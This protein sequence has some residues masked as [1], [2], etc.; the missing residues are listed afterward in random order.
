M[1]T[2]QM[3][4]I[5][6]FMVK[7]MAKRPCYQEE[8]SSSTAFLSGLG[9]TGKT[10]RTVLAGMRAIAKTKEIDNWDLMT[11][12][13]KE[14]LTLRGYDFEN[15]SISVIPRDE[16][17]IQKWVIGSNLEPYDLTLFF[18]KSTV[19]L[20]HD[21]TEGVFELMPAGFAC[22]G[23]TEMPGYNGFCNMFSS[24][25]KEWAAALAAPVSKGVVDYLQEISRNGS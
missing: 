16:K 3:P 23:P 14:I 20:L 1:T 25:I 9:L 19:V 2:Y 8:I 6:E 21:K 18:T 15:V 13:I 4:Q 11:K 10:V 22:L 24:S 5:P 7:Q 12:L 17:D